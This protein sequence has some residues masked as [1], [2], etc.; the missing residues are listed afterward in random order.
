MSS[1]NPLSAAN[2]SWNSDHGTFSQ[3]IDTGFSYCAGPTVTLYNHHIT[4]NK[5]DNNSDCASYQY[6]SYDS[7]VDTTNKLQLIGTADQGNLLAPDDW[8]HIEVEFS[9]SSTTTGFVKIKVNRSSTDSSLDGDFTSVQTTSQPNNNARI[10]A[11]GTF[12]GHINNGLDSYTDS[13]WNTYIDDIVIIDCSDGVTPTGFIGPTQCHRIPYDTANSITGDGTLTD[14]DEPFNGPAGLV[15]KILLDTTDE[16]IKV[17]ASGLV[18]ENDIIAIQPVVY[19][20]NT[21]G[22]S[23]LE[24]STTINATTTDATAKTL[25][26]DPVNGGLTLGPVYTETP[27]G[28][29]L[30]QTNARQI[31]FNNIVK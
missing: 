14:V 15:D 23:T 7:I 1:K 21:A 16:E 27:E 17:S 2:Y 4:V 25:S 18:A 28:S 24:F 8:N 20:Y 12:W 31:I 29:N 10:Y 19:G 22:S 5:T 30:N 26:D 11:F 13:G 3:Q 9:L 6:S